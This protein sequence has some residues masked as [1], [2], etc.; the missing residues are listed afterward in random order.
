MKRRK[1]FELFGLGV[2]TA[3]VAP[4]I[5]T[6]VVINVPKE[7]VI[8]ETNSIEGGLILQ[9]YT[10]DPKIISKARRSPT[11]DFISYE[12]FLKIII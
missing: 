4:K 11:R 12:E 5:V 2:T 3:V 6:E 7:V 9:G 8:K 10:I 1:F